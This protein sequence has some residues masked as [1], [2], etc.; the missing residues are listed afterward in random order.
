VRSSSS[1]HR[2]LPNCGRFLWAEP[3]SPHR[4]A[5]EVFSSPPAPHEA[6][7]AVRDWTKQK[8]TYLVCDRVPQDLGTCRDSLFRVLVNARIEDSGIDPALTQSY[9]SRSMRAVCRYFWNN[10]HDQPA[11]GTGLDA[12]GIGFSFLNRQKGN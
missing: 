2:R 8:V 1:P 9:T 6:E 11:F 5:S 12:N 10:A 3:K 4:H 7:P